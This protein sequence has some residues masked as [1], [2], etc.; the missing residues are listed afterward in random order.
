LDRFELRWIDP[1]E[2]A[3]LES[4]REFARAQPLDRVPLLAS[5]DQPCL[6]ERSRLF[7]VVRSGRR[8][9]VGARVEGVFPYPS[10]PIF[11]V[12]PGGAAAAATA[13][14]PPF[15][16]YAGERIW[17]ELAHA[18]GRALSEELQMARLVRV[19][20]ADRD[21]RVERLS[22]Y[23]ELARFAER[24]ISRVHFECGPYF[25]VRDDTGELTSIGGVQL[26]TD[27]VAQLGGIATS[28][29]ARRQGLA[30][31]VVTE[32]IRTLEEKGRTIV[33]HVQVDNHAAIRLYAALGFR[34][35]RRIRLYSFQ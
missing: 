30:R 12:V 19:P 4:L 1:G 8:A 16:A 5:L 35:R 26:V 17:S 34:G 22:D 10:A 31:A 23:E 33:L 11:E 18:G 28:P 2:G 9:A 7:E 27:T 15:V 20:L 3:A 6:A 13:L 25:G 32:L 21:P 14:E 24:A 29:E